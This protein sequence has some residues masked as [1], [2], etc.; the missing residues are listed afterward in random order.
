MLRDFP[1]FPLQAST[2][3][4]RED[5]LFFF[6]VAVSAFFVALIFLLILLFAVR[7]RRRSPEERAR[8]VREP[9]WL[10]LAWTLIPLGLTVIIFLWGARLFFF[11]S[12]P[13]ANAME[14][15]VVGKQWMWRL[16][17]PEGPREI[18]ELHVP[19]G[20][21][22]KLTMTSEDVIHSFF[23]PAFRI[24]R[25]VVPGRY[26]T[27][28]FEATKTGEYHLFCTQY[29]GTQ[30][31][32]M[33]GRVIVMEPVEYER[34]LRGGGAGL[35]P[36]AQGE[37]LFQRLACGA[38]HRP[39]NTGRGPSLVGLFGQPVRL[40]GGGT[41]TA[42]EG[43]IRE[44]IL[45]PQAKIVAGFQPIMPTFKGQV[46]EEGILQIIAYIKS[47]GPVERARAKP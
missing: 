17:H 31:A 39:D 28:W 43:Y 24:K 9:L 21:P 33:I 41:A 30:H 29:C 27:A 47:L 32:G 2:Y 23:V 3:A 40:E 20:T 34:W 26:I 38:C 25:D 4:A 35:L 6:L 22:V 16:Q 15:N 1:L 13:P 10:E 11:A 37:V 5:A 12:R 42:D 45:M 8:S 18:N 19:V 7:Y 46:S 44:S 36:A 14:I